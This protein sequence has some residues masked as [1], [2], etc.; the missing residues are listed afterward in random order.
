MHFTNAREISNLV[1]STD[2]LLKNGDFFMTYELRTYVIPQGK[3]DDI[4]NRFKNVTMRLFKKHEMEVVGFWTVLQ[5]GEKNTLIY[6]MRFV[7]EEAM[8]KAWSAFRSDEEWITTREKTEANGPI[9][10]EVK[11]ELL[12]PTSF[13]SLQ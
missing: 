3:M 5:T 8:N 10:E 4:L 2:I 9:V 12:T 11:S 13:S 7:D 1:L 6:L